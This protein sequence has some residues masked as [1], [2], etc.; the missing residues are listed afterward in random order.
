MTNDLDGTVACNCMYGTMDARCCVNRARRRE[1]EE[2]HRLGREGKPLPPAEN[3][4][5]LPPSWGWGKMKLEG[6]TERLHTDD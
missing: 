3:E 4:F 2:A 6:F 1:L 5:K